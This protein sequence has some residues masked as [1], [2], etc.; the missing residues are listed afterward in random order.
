MTASEGAE[1]SL[2]NCH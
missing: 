2:T 1:H